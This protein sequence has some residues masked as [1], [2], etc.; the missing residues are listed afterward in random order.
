MHIPKM[1]DGPTSMFFFRLMLIDNTLPSFHETT[2]RIGSSRGTKRMQATK[3]TKYENGRNYRELK[4]SR[5]Y[6]PTSRFLPSFQVGWWSIRRYPRRLNNAS[7]T[8]ARPLMTTIASHHKS[9]GWSTVLVYGY[10][11]V[12]NVDVEGRLICES[13]VHLFL[14]LFVWSKQMCIPITIS[15]ELSFAEKDKLYETQMVLVYSLMCSNTMEKWPCCLLS[16]I[17]RRLSSIKG[18][19]SNILKGSNDEKFVALV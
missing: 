17:L 13:E 19:L 8:T 1:K 2:L 11:L 12:I 4:R 15:S 3:S 16:C 5:P 6:Q 10:V 9:Y 7:V 18:E 14:D